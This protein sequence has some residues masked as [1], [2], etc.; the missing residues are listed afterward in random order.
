LNELASDEAADTQLREWLREF[1]YSD[2]E[3]AEVF[4]L[5][6]SE[7]V[8]DIIAQGRHTVREEIRTV[9]IPT[10]LVPGHMHRG[11]VEVDDLRP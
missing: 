11:L 5:A 2:A 10:L 4:E 6:N 8:A 3:I 1:G 7:Q 9:T